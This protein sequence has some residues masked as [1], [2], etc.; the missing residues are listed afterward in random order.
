MALR[1][2]AR[3]ASQALAERTARQMDYSWPQRG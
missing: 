1:L 3:L 2:V